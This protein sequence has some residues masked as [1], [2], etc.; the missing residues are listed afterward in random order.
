MKFMKGDHSSAELGPG[1]ASSWSTIPGSGIT[2]G[3]V[4]SLLGMGHSP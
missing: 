3:L 1:E 4:G 2:N